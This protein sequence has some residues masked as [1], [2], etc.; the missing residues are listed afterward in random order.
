MPQ[1][2]YWGFK[3]DVVAWYSCSDAPIWTLA[4]IPITNNGSEIS[5]DTDSRYN[6]GATLVQSIL[7]TANFNLHIGRCSHHHTLIFII[8]KMVSWYRCVSGKK[9]MYRHACLI[10]IKEH[11]TR[12]WSW[13]PYCTVNYTPSGKQNTVRNVKHWWEKLTLYPGRPHS[14]TQ[15]GLILLI[16]QSGRCGHGQWFVPVEKHNT[17]QLT[18]TLSVSTVW[19]LSSR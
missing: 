3:F 11:T 2:V 15:A 7:F 18:N 1:D 6:I 4:D 13:L 9:Y 17:M 8:E 19:L 16:V 12:W 5:A 10:I 14:C